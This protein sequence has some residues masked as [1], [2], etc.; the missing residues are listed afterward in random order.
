MPAHPWI[1]RGVTLVVVA[2]CTATLPRIW[3][4][5][6][7]K[8]LARDDAAAEEALARGV[9]RMVDRSSGSGGLLTGNERFDGEWRMVTEQMTALGL[10]QLVLERPERR[11]EYLPVIAR[12]VERLQ[13]DNVTAFGQDA[14]G[15]RGFDDLEGDRGHAYLG[16]ANM[17]FGMLRLLDRR[18]PIGPL[19][20]RVTL[21]LARRLAQAPGAVIETYPGETYPADVA[22]V[23][24]SIALHDRATSPHNQPLLDRWL[25]GFLERYVD[26]HSGLLY[27]SVDARSGTPLGP[28]RA[29]GTAIAVYFL[30]FVDDRAARELFAAISRQRT[31][32]LG[33]GGIREYPSG[34]SGSSDIDSGPLFLGV[35]ASASA[36]T[37]AGARLY[38]ES[39]LLIELLRTASFVGL[40]MEDGGRLSF[41]S[42]GPLGNAIV[43]A[44]LTARPALVP[45]HARPR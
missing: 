29:S 7:M 15:R 16:Y 32:F 6:S 22:A 8:G 37:L 44:A 10:G 12:S 4:E 35:S 3:H 20:D 28:P 1:R 21:A 45:P 27:Q 23:A 38:G 26:P 30:S 36:F 17:A 40:P 24:A 39:S 18:A 25:R 34:V 19:H 42:G 41:A 13:R 2:L 14:W 31:S 9:I 5:Q 33:F 43:L 11:A